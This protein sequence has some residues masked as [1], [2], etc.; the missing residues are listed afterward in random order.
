M[1]IPSQKFEQNTETIIQETTTSTKRAKHADDS[2]VTKSITNSKFENFTNLTDHSSVIM[3]DGSD[4]SSEDELIQPKSLDFACIFCKNPCTS[5]EKAVT[6]YLKHLE[7]FYKCSQCDSNFLTINEFN[8]HN[9]KHEFK[10]QLKNAMKFIAARQWV[11]DFLKNM[12]TSRKKVYRNKKEPIHCIVCSLNKNVLN[13]KNYEDIYCMRSVEEHLYHHLQYMPYRCIECALEYRQTDKQ[14]KK[15]LINNF[16]KRHLLF[17]HKIDISKMTMKEV[18][19]Y[20]T[21]EFTEI[22]KLDE[23]ILNYAKINEA[24]EITNKSLLL[25]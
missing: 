8:N 13:I 14:P 11:C 15:F 19:S 3:T 10:G 20:Y 25:K 18:S 6:H 7:V 4:E 21:K 22:G 12:E 1:A 2:V 16:A 9:I 5:Y 23:I 17:P 24:I